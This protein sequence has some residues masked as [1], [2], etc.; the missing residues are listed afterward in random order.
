MFMRTVLAITLLAGTASI[1]GCATSGPSGQA[2]I[3]TW[4]GASVD[5]LYLAYGP[6]SDSFEQ[7]DGNKLVEFQHSDLDS[8]T[9][10]YC[11]VRYTV[12]PAGTILGG[13]YEGNIGGCNRLIQTYQLTP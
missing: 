4:T 12:D 3:E 13:T 9:P 6:P 11:T 8:S 10:Y 1:A 5:A 7:E 2:E